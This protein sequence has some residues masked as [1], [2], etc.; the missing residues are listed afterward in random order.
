MFIGFLLLAV[1]GLIWT[2]VGIIFSKAT[3]DNRD[4]TGFLL[5]SS[6]I[7]AIAIWI[8]RTPVAAPPVEIW[9]TAAAIVPG[10][11][12]SLL[13]FWTLFV[14]MR[15]GSHALAWIFTQSAMIIPF[16][17]GWMFFGN[18]AEWLNWSGML[19][20]AAALVLVGRSK[21][22]SDTN[23]L[24]KSDGLKWSLIA[25]V[26]VG[27]SQ[28]LTLLPG[29]IGIGAEALTWRL[30][31]QTVPALVVWGVVACFK[32]QFPLKVSIKQGIIYG[33]VVISGQVT[34]Y[35][36]IDQLGKYNLANIV[37]PVAI[38]ICIVLFTLF[39]AVWRK[40]RI[41]VWSSIGVSLLVC[42]TALLFS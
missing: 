35:M 2:A 40:E 26:L 31:L 7:S 14:A 27:V 6:A 1:T 42:G 28:L 33:L 3:Q 16:V 22:G 20:I 19:L 25:M 17:G 15:K 30:P 38:N 41:T 12:L 23:A 18:K 13:G 39:C 37:Y 21:C 24:A 29:E 36:S 4:F 8:T 11:V 9:K 32:K 34:L 5:V 10:A